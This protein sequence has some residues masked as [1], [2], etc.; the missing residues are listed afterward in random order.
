GAFDD[1]G[2]HLGDMVPLDSKGRHWRMYYIGYQKQIKAKF[3]AFTGVAESKDGANTFSKCSNVPIIDR[4]TESIAIRA[5]HCIRRERGG[6]RAWYSCGDGWEMLGGK[7]YPRYFSKTLFSNDGLS[8]ADDGGK[9][10]VPRKRNEYRIGRCRIFK[11]PKKRGEFGSLAIGT[12]DGK[13]ATHCI[14]RPNQSAPWT[15]AGYWMPPSQ[16]KAVIGV[17]TALNIAPILVGDRLM[18]FYNDDA[19]DYEGV[20]WAEWRPF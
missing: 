1:N 20:S 10:I 5:L 3:F 12:T 11:I 2:V 7:A 6:F 18:A 14:Y 15:R 8:F 16:R 4:S 17:Y 13:Y 19:A 9:D